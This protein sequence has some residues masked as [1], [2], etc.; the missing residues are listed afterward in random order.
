MYQQT[1]QSHA[2]VQESAVLP[3]LNVKPERYSH[4]RLTGATDASVTIAHDAGV[5]RIPIHRL[6]AAQ[7]VGLNG[8]SKAVQ[9]GLGVVPEKVRESDSTYSSFTSKLRDAG[10]GILNFVQRQTG[11][12]VGTMEVWLL[13]GIFP[14]L[15]VILIGVN[16]VQG[17]RLKARV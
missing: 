7:I 12:V 2:T 16:V 1:N 5:A 17:R 6:E 10:M 4:V 14:L 8:T 15:I 13:F 3:L 9:V 11:I